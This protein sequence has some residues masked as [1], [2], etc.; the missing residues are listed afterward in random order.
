MGTQQ[1]YQASAVC[2]G[3]IQAGRQHC[4]KFAVEQFGN[5]VNALV[6]EGGLKAGQDREKARKEARGVI[7]ATQCWRR[8]SG[9]D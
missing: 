3:E 2:V 7:S 5:I 6:G 4:G 9:T 8:W 1:S